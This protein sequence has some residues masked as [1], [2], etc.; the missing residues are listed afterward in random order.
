MSGS[1]I[2]RIPPLHAALTSYFESFWSIVPY[3]KTQMQ[4]NN[5]SVVREKSSKWV[6]EELHTKLLKNLSFIE[7]VNEIV[8]V[9]IF[10]TRGL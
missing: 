4:I 10:F 1:K 8:S 7:N 5:F 2:V 9:N 3:M 6:F